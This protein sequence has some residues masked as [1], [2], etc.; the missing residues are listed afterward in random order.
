[1]HRLAAVSL[2]LGYAICLLSCSVPLAPELLD[3]HFPMKKS[4]LR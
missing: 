3:A 4:A 1:L 2:S